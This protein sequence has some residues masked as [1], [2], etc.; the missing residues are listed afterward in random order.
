MADSARKSIGLCMGTTGVS[1][2]VLHQIANDLPEILAFSR[3]PS[4]FLRAG[5]IVNLEALE[6][7]ISECRQSI[8]SLIRTS[9]YNTTVNLCGLD[10]RIESGTTAIDFKRPTEIR[11]R[12]LRDAHLASSLIEDAQWRLVHIFPA[13]YDV[14]S[15]TSLA[16]PVGLIGNKLSSHLRQVFAPAI[17]IDGILHAMNR[18]GLGVSHIVADPLGAFEALVTEEE[19]EMGLWILDIGGSVIQ[20]AFMKGAE[21]LLPTPLPIG[22][23]TVTS[24]I[25]IGLNTTIRDA[26]KIKIEHGRVLPEMA[27]DDLMVHIPPLGGGRSNNPTSQHRLAEIIKSRTEEMFELAGEL[28]GVQTESDNISSSVVLTGGGSLLPGTIELAAKYLGM[29]IIEGHLRNVSGLTDI[30]PVP[31][32]ASAVGLALYGLRRD[33]DLRWNT[34]DHSRFRHIVHKMVSWFGGEA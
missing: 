20:A 28:I 34:P 16:S 23:D 4:R 3:V 11:R 21:I 2:A 8:S 24:D 18:C 32:C 33:R 19:R 30:A 26:E 10:L 1:I 6:D 22:G 12:H 17:A 25:A 5:M 9:F 7:A 13:S 15:Q 31:L 29:P 14:D 27:S